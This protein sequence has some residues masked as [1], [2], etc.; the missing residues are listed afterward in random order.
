MGEATI[1]L[2]IVESLASVVD[3]DDWLIECVIGTQPLQKRLCCPTA[4]ARRLLLTKPLNSLSECDIELA[5]VRR[6]Y[7]YSERI[8][9]TRGEDDPQH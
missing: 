5:H 9:I 1:V 4:V 6:Q 3:G 7:R 8:A 2:H